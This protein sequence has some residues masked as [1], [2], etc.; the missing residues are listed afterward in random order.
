MLLN[1]M[2]KAIY[3]TYG[4]KGEEIVNMNNAAIDRGGEVE[5]L[6]SRLNGQKLRSSLT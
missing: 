5:K 6:R 3:K 1:D 4:R 2:K